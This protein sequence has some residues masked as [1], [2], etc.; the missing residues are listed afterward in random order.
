MGRNSQYNDGGANKNQASTSKKPS[1]FGSVYMDLTNMM[2][3]E[4]VGMAKGED[5]DYIGLNGQSKLQ[6]AFGLVSAPFSLP[7]AY[8]SAI[9]A[10]MAIASVIDQP[11]EK[12]AEKN[13]KPKTPNRDIM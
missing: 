4:F 13:K 9:P 3:K 7:L 1:S 5:S 11:A 12:T 6:R 8:V 2:R 10:A